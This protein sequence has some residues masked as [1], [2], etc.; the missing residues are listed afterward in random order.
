MNLLV[1][2]TPKRNTEVVQSFGARLA[3][4]RKAAGYT[5]VEFATDVDITQCMVAYS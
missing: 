5:Q 2:P 3:Q 1:N 4:L